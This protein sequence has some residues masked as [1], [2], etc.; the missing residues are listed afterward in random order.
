[1]RL[2][3]LCKKLENARFNGNES[4]NKNRQGR[5]GTTKMLE[6]TQTPKQ[7]DYQTIYENLRPEF[8]LPFLS[9]ACLAFTRRMKSSLEVWLLSADALPVY[10]LTGT[11]S[12]VVGIDMGTRVLFALR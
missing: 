4:Q 8:F 1:M 5:K 7:P 10:V 2:E 12:Y 3:N 11:T 6:Q 9:A